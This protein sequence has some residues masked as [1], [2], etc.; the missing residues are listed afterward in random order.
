M[1]TRRMT[2]I[3]EKIF[4]YFTQDDWIEIK[5]HIKEVL[6]KDIENVIDENYIFDADFIRKTEK[7]YLQESVKDVVKEIFTDQDI[8]LKEI[9]RQVI[10]EELRK[11]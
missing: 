4:G 2:N 1:G 11:G 10:K 3:Q 6:K 5:E 7:E 8:K 9:I